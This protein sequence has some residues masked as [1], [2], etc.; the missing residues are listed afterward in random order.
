MESSTIISVLQT[1]AGI[2]LTITSGLVGWCIKKIFD[3][4]NFYSGLAARVDA[5]SRAV[6]E[7]LRTIVSTTNRQFEIIERSNV[8]RFDALTDWNKSISS[9]LDTII[10]NGRRKE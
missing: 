5:E 2:L 8:Q 9:K 4:S 6:D 1:V 3:L 7:R 10:A